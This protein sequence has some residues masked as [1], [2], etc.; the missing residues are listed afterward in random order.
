MGD[1][2]RASVRY[3]WMKSC[4]CDGLLSNEHGLRGVEA[5]EGE[6]GSESGGLNA[7]KAG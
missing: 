3:S 5:R 7:R 2:A 4:H 1:L 6:F